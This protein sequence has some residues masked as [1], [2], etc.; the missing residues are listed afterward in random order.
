[1]PPAAGSAATSSLVPRPSCGPRWGILI[2]A[3]QRS[4]P[5]AAGRTPNAAT[6]SSSRGP[7]HL[8][9]RNRGIAAQDLEWLA[10]EASPGRRT[11]ALPVAARPG[12]PRTTWLDHAAGRTA[13]CARRRARAGQRAGA[14]GSRLHR[15]P[16]ASHRARARR[17]S[18]FYASVSLHAVIVP[19]DP[20]LAAAIEARVR[21]AIN[22]FLHP[23]LD[24][25][26]DRRGWQFG[27][28][29]V[30]ALVHRRRHRRRR[31]RR[32][33]SPPASTAPLP[34]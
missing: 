12:R 21:T 16:P 25:G 11:R 27:E 28:Q 1:M 13:S 19:A 8:R 32:K 6:T 29:P 2:G 23:P 31:A 14:H 22:R 24:G 7:Q 4:T 17:G 20:S 18:A 15:R 9:H 34:A 30:G 10:L 5:A 33:T 26:N 3:S